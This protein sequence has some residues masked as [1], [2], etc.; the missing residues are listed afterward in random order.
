[1]NLSDI[2][3]EFGVEF[4]PDYLTGKSSGA[5]YQSRGVYVTKGPRGTN[6]SF[7]F[8]VNPAD[9]GDLVAIGFD[10]ISDTNSRFANIDSWFSDRRT[11]HLRLHDLSNVTRS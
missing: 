5:I 2:L 8:D 9:I 11:M 3:A 10:I 4:N 6:I 7:T 1:M